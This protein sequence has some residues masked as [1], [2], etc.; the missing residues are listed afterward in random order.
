MFNLFKKKNKR[1]KKVQ[2]PFP[3]NWGMAFG[4]ALV[5]RKGNAGLDLSDKAGKVIKIQGADRNYVVV[6]TNPKA[7]TLYLD[8]NP[9]VQEEIIGFDYVD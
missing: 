1:V 7:N 2:K 4:D 9:P 5:I 6:S 3:K 8:G